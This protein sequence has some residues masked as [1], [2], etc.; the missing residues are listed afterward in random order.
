MRL[1]PITQPGNRL[2][3]CFLLCVIL[4][5]AMSAGQ[6]AE[7]KITVTLDGQLWGGQSGAVWILPSDP[8][9]R[10][11]KQDPRIEA[12]E[13]SGLTLPGG[14]GRTPLLMAIAGQTA[15]DMY[16]CWSHII[17]NDVSQGFIHPLNEWI[18]EDTNHNGQIDLD[19]AKWSGWKDIPPL[20]RRI[21]TVDGK[22]YGLPVVG[23]QH[24]G[25][26]Y[27]LDL[28]RQA[29]LDANK[30]PKTWDEFMYWC[31]KMTDP[32]KG[33]YA[34]AIPALGFTWLPWFN[35]A[36][37]SPVIQIKTSPKTGKKYTFPMEATSF[38]APDTGEDLVGAPTDWRSDIDSPPAV[39]SMEFFHRL[40]WQRW[41]RDPQTGEPVNMTPKEAA[42]GHI[43]LANGREIKFK[44]EDVITGVARAWGGQTAGYDWNQKMAR[45][46]MAMVEWF[47]D[48]MQSMEQQYGINPGLLGAFPI[49]AGPGGK[50]VIQV[51]RHYTVMTEGVGRRSKEERDAV[52]KV[53]TALT[54]KGAY[55]DNIRRQV[56]AGS[57]RFVA[58]NDLIRLGYSG[59]LSEVPPSL[60][61]IYTGLKDGSIITRTEP[62]AG[63]WD[64][65]C[66]ALNNNVLGLVLSDSGENENYVKDLHEVNLS[67]NTGTM[68]E[69]KPE[70]VSRYRPLAWTIFCVVAVVVLF[71][72]AMI[73]KTNLT[74]ETKTGKARAGVHRAWVPW[75]LLLPALGL[76]GVWG[77]YPLMRG[78]VMA[79]QNYHIVGSK[80][81][82][83]LD[84]FINI[85]LNP[86]FY[87]YIRQTLKFVLLN[88]VFAF[89]APIMLS[90][91]LSEIPRFKIFWR[92]VFFLPQLTS[93]LVITLL[94][95][96]MYN[97]ADAGL[98]NQMLKT[99]C[100]F[101]NH[102]PFLHLK[103][104]A[105][106]WLGNPVTA[107]MATIVPGIWAGMGMASL[108]YLA[109]LKGIPD[110]LYEAAD[111][112]G[113]G[114]FGKLR[115]ITIPQLMPLIIINFVG[116]FIGTF[117]SIG[118]IFLLTFGGPGKETMVMSMAIWL[119]AYANLRFSIA[120]AMAWIL[121]SALI[122]FAYLQ[123]RVLRRVEFRRVDEV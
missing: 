20:V 23:V 7:Q 85:F 2:V 81:W 62:F 93:G 42:S 83:G 84:N 75:L 24:M 16:Y 118:N 92:S 12:K 47:Y 29:G 55:D 100:A 50:Q 60:N 65:L 123:I 17:R 101:L 1:S 6:S 38:I 39:K 108:I 14:S 59:Y 119:E 49:P 44:S 32:K 121:G 52:W 9:I 43:K 112:D 3:V 72:V 105:V 61:Q 66:N 33:R 97:S 86:D 10:L 64:T 21:A 11:M 96:L 79:F 51:Q 26:I 15:P 19:E 104:H 94:W 45:G 22:V 35:S 87:I 69:R 116:A 4:L 110:E 102:F 48:G 27:R 91:I 71:F 74:A 109:A 58:P 122:G 90:L 34:F 68:F 31:Q 95:K 40:R 37:G 103:Y 73:I 111:L 89:T 28:A 78:I 120:T 106:D 56:I 30:T 41:I 88:L 36:G 99:L 70:E 114:I 107:M 53:M 18:G 82:V 63:F 77:Y 117:Q 115:F 8:V 57:A 80:P 113:A 5:A 67:A 25:I 54:S 76:I 98:L 13:W 46:E